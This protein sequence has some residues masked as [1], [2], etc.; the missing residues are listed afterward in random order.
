MRTALRRNGNEPGG[1][2]GKH[3]F[4]VGISRNIAEL[5]ALCKRLR[6]FGYD[7]AYRGD[8]EPTVGCRKRGFYV[9]RCDPAAAYK[10]I[11]H[12]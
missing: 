5:E 9:I 11:F 3:F 8:L 10:C 2:V 1:D 7:V 4:V 12:F 6:L